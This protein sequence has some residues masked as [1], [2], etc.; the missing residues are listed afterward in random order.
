MRYI[1]LKKAGKLEESWKTGKPG[2]VK[3]K[4]LA[5]MARPRH[6]RQ[7]FNNLYANT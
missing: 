6:R 5:N 2:K 4:M 1:A 7:E 3:V